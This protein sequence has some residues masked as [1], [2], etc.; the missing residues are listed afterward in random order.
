MREGLQRRAR[1]MQENLQQSVGLY[2]IFSVRN[3]VVLLN[4]VCRNSGK[5]SDVQASFLNL[6]FSK[7]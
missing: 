7:A 5:L 6:F 2:V 1:R 3:K 4:I